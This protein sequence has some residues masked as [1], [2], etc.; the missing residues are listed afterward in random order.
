M[1]R[2]G[3]F[4]EFVRSKFDCEN[5]DSMARF[6]HLFAEDIVKVEYEKREYNIPVYYDAEI[7]SEEESGAVSHFGFLFRDGRHSYTGV[8]LSNKRIIDV[9]DYF[10]IAE[11]ENYCYTIHNVREA[12]GIDEEFAFILFSILHEFAHYID[13]EKNCNKSPSQYESKYCQ[14]FKERKRLI[15][16]LKNNELTGKEFQARYNKDLAMESCAND[17]ASRLIANYLED[18]Y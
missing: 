5:E 14:A 2:M 10:K 6:A 15:K 13:F 1:N 8:H 11:N 16:Q 7:V 12:N 17:I 9:I 3:T 4:K 18:S